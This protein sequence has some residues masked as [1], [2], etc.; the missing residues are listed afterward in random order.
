LVNANGQPF[1]IY[2][3][4]ERVTVELKYVLYTRPT[5][6]VRFWFCHVSDTTVHRYT[7]CHT[8]TKYLDSEPTRP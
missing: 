3:K 1:F 7:W 5:H 8:P 4:V 2:I 6:L